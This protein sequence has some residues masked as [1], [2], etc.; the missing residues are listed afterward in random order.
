[1]VFSFLLGLPLLTLSVH[2][3]SAAALPDFQG[4]FPH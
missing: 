4:N 1:M 3:N 2:H